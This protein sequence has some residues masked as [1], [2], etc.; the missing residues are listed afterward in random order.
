[1]MQTAETI[2]PQ[3]QVHTVQ[4]LADVEPALN[5]GG[6]RWTIFQ[7]KDELLEAGAIFYNGRK[8]LIDRD[9]YIACLR[10]GL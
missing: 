8:L 9:R 4:T 5:E 10:S 6:I 1:M 3:G 2:E 7:H